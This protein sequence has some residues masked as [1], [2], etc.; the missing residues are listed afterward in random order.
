MKIADVSVPVKTG[1]MAAGTACRLV[2]RPER[3]IKGYRYSS[4]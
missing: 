2:L 3:N 1:D 4:M